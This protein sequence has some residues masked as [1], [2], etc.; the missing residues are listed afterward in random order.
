[1]LAGLLLRERE[2]ERAA[3]SFSLRFDP[4]PSS[5]R[6]YDPLDP[7]Q[8]H[9]RALAATVQAFEEAEDVLL[10][11]GRDAD[12]VVAHVAE[13]ILFATRGSDLEAQCCLTRSPSLYSC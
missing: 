5:V 4:G 13:D 1:M 9:A 7:R 10:K 8:P 2:P 12:P 6:L 3:V 11:P